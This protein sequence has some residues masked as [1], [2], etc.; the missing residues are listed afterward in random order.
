MWEVDL[1]LRL[2]FTKEYMRSKNFRKKPSFSF[3]TVGTGVISKTISS[4]TNTGSEGRDEISTEVLKRF[5]DVL[6]EP[7]R[8]IV[9]QSIRM[10]EYPDGWKTGVITPLPKSGDLTN[11][12][13]WRPVCI[14]PAPSKVLEKVLQSQFQKYMETQ[15]IFSSSQHAYRE[16]RSCESAL[17]DLD[18]LVQK[19]R[20]EG[21][22]VALV[23]TDMSAT[24]N[25]ID[26]HILLAQFKEYGVTSKARTLVHSYLTG[27]RTRCK[28]KNFTSRDVELKSGVGEGSVLGPIFFIGGMVSVP[29]VATRTEIESRARNAEVEANTLEFADDTSGVLSSKTEVELQTGINVM[30]SKFKLYFES[31]GMALNPS[32]CQLLVIRS[33]KKV[34]TLTLPGGQEEVR[35]VKLL[36]LHIDNNYRFQTHTQQVCNK[37]RFK[38][39]NLVRVRQYMEQEKFKRV[40]EALV[41]SVVDYAGILYLRLKV[42]QVRVQKLINQAARIVLKADARAHIVDLLLATGWLNCENRLEFLQCCAMRRMKTLKMRA[43]VS[44][45]E[46]FRDRGVYQLRAGDLRK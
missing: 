39:A 5:K 42:N 8:H 14:L 40:M 37:L 12:K 10:G 4:L 23:L 2:D 24:F 7:L 43:P 29:T 18:T 1:Y 33:R 6:A 3:Q 27:R 17:I 16:G 22:V 25:L 44:Y 13:Y 21:K 11:P 45:Q 28:I 31:M 34:N 26:K 46:I 38:L 9:N 41:L 19:A 30:F 32:K 36:G 15:G 35:T 20:N